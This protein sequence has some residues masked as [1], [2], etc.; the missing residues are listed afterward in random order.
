M[1]SHVSSNRRL[2]VDEITIAVVL[3]HITGPVVS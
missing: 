1:A 3:D 2:I